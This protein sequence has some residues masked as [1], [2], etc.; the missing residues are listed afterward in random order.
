YGIGN[1]VPPGN[2]LNR[3]MGGISAGV[4]DPQ[5]INFLNPATYGNFVY[6]TFDLGGEV[7]SRTLKNKVPVENFTANN[8]IISYIQ[9]GVPLLNGNKKAVKKDISWGLNFGLRPVSKI[10]Y[11]I[12]TNGRLAGI[13]ST[14]TIYEGSGGVNEAFIGT[15][16]KIKKFSI[17]F[18]TGYLFGN[19]NYSTRLLLVNDTVAYNASNSS[20]QTNFGG[21]FFNAGIQ[22][23]TKIKGGSLRIGAYGTLSKKYNATQ[24]ILRETFSYNPTSGNP[25]TIDSVFHS[26]GEKGTIQMPATYG[27]GFSIEKTHWLLGA[28]VEATNWDNYSFYGQKDAV[29][30]TWLLKAGAQYFPGL[31]GSKKY[32]NFVKYRAGFYYGPDYISADNKLPQYGVSIGAGF[33]LK[34]NHTF[35]DNQYSTMNVAV[36]YGSRGNKNNNIRENIL[37]VSV[38]FSLS[39]VWFL[40]EKYH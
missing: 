38:G 25:E 31:S 36:E 35:Y 39:D 21:L 5:A 12:Q 29:K 37:R 6:T 28:D 34:L 33:P 17:G 3:G 4:A 24:D 23:V 8:A 26:N 16:V 32:W 9:I 22:Y 40:R 15:G 1:L 7:D 10:N 18:N 14:Q 11:K 13:D 30:N 27:A 19:K 20:N 2:I